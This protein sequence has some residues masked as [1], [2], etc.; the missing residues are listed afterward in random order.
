M[1]E[2]PTYDAPRN[3][4]DGRYFPEYIFVTGL[5]TNSQSKGAPLLALLRFLRLA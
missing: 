5:R 1:A 3:F 4:N 2:A